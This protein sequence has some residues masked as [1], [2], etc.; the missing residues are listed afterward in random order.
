MSKGGIVKTFSFEALEDCDNKASASQDTKATPPARAA[1]PGFVAATAKEADQSC[2]IPVI[3]EPKDPA[4]VSPHK[5][6]ETKAPGPVRKANPFLNPEEPEETKMP[7]LLAKAQ[8]VTATRPPPYLPNRKAYTGS[9]DFALARRVGTLGRYLPKAFTMQ[10][11]DLNSPMNKKRS[12]GAMS[13]T[14]DL[15]ER[16]FSLTANSATVLNKGMSESI[17]LHPMYQEQT[18]T[19]LFC[20]RAD[21][22]SRVQSCNCII[23]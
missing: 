2:S 16:N 17:P 21:G 9:P 7:A 18:K 8:T 11:E 19:G 22:Q 20:C 15:K 14:L 5:T 10:V 13:P 23:I 4:R 12:L 1:N 3:N 6:E